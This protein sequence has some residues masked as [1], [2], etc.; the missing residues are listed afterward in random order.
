MKA[1]VIAGTPGTGKKSVAAELSK[2]TG[3]EKLGLSELALSERLFLDYDQEHNT[4]IVD[5]DR[6]VDRV[7][8]R[9]KS[10]DKPVIIHTHFPELVPRELVGFVFV[11]RTHPLVL[12]KRLASRGWSQRKINENVMAEILGVVAYNALEAF[13]PDV[14]YEVDTSNTTPTSV[15]ETI[16][17]VIRGTLSLRPGIFIDWLSTL[18]PDLVE[19][20]G[21]Y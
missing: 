21:D 4:Y 10:S 2:L 1:I 13:G 8:D 3:Y 9:V 14:V 6:L 20:Y 7:V 16:L 17:G 19:K 11:L 12:E 5:E 18:P 15:A